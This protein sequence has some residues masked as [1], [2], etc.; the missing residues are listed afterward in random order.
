M[1]KIA[2]AFRELRKLGYV[3]KRNFR[4]CNTCGWAALTEEEAEKAVFIHRQ[5]ERNWR[6]DGTTHLSW[7]GDGDEIFDVM[8][9]NGLNPLWEGIPTKKIQIFK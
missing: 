6:E 3:A 9:R 7:S 4:C 1:S 2:K 8:E 5:S